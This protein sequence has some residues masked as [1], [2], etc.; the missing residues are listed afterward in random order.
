MQ[1]KRMTA[2]SRSQRY[3]FYLLCDNNFEQKTG[4]N[5]RF[6][7]ESDLPEDIHE[8]S[9]INVP[10]FSKTPGRLKKNLKVTKLRKKTL[11]RPSS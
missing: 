10:V 1:K 6:P 4:L 9:A 7:A 8:M 11:H 2:W 3:T 5:Q